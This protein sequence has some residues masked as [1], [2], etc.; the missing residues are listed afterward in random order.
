M[1]AGPCM[2]IAPSLQG[3][4]SREGTALRAVHPMTGRAELR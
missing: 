4:R 2:E 1:S 3:R